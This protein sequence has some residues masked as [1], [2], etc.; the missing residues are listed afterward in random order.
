MT[1]VTLEVN[2]KKVTKDVADHTILSIFLR[3][4]LVNVVHV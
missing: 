1:K 3:D 4:N 2:G